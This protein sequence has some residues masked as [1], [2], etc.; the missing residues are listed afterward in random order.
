MNETKKL[1]GERG[2]P[3]GRWQLVGGHPALD[4]VNTVDWR[5]RAAP[6]DT[7]LDYAG[8]LAWTQLAR[9]V[10]PEEAADLA[11]QAAAEP[12]QATAALRRA[13]ELREAAYR[14]VRAGAYGGDAAP[15]DLARLNAVLRRYPLAAELARTSSG[16]AWHRPRTMPDLDDPLRRLAAAAADLLTAADLRR[17]KACGA[18]ECGW[19]FLDTSPSRRRRWCSME[20]CGNRAKARRHYARQRPEES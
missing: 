10:N 13:K 4:F 15:E 9:L 7:L 19:L 18:A 11:R 1:G 8:L 3:G 5:G 6:L 2:G 20:S 17:V 12:E 14:L 16:F